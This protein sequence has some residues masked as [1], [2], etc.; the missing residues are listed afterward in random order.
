MKRIITIKD[1]DADIEVENR[2][3][4]GIM[5]DC[6]LTKGLA[7]LKPSEARKIASALNEAADEQERPVVLAEGNRNA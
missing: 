3:S 1:L 6:G 2:G 7:F 5:L 4:A